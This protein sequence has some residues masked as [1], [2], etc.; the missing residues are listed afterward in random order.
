MLLIL[1]Y[2]Y[3]TIELE[4]KEGDIL[5]N[6]NFAKKIN[7]LRKEKNLSQKEFGD[8]L[9]VSNKA[10]SKWETGESLPKM[11]TIIKIAEIYG[12][13]PNELLTG[14]PDN[15]KEEKNTYA[16]EEYENL[17]KENLFLQSE[18]NN[19][20]KKSKKILISLI[21]V[22]IVMV[23]III[24]AC[25]VF[26]KS[27]QEYNNDLKDLG[28]KGTYIVFEN[29]IFEPLNNFENLILKDSSE[30]YFAEDYY[31]ETAEQQ[32][33]ADFIDT[34]G[35]KHKALINFSSGNS[36]VKLDAGKSSYYYVKKDSHLSLN[37]KFVTE[38]DFVKNVSIVSD[39]HYDGDYE[40][41]NYYFADSDDKII[42]NFCR[43]YKNKKAVKDKKITELY[44]GNKSVSTQI[45]FSGNLFT[46]RGKIG[47][48]FKDNNGK[49]YYYD[50]VDSITYYVPGE[51]SAYVYR[52]N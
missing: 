43:F 52:Q 1:E 27:S 30:Y 40:D 28:Q 48:F 4:M 19:K 14:I 7:E 24:T 20:N 41:D 49:T 42:K 35:T 39:S 50:Y 44:M 29:E 25:V 45:F 34:R 18:L 16:E 5:D 33:Y 12:I 21:S 13:N 11:K 47:E 2:V 17:K 8:L 15:K 38:I 31:L 22:C 23:L 10:V 37:E 36:Y 6:Y 26:E 9:S 51:V 3:G 46:C 32:K